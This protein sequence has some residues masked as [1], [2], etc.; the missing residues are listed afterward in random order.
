MFE[1]YHDLV[2]KVFQV[3]TPFRYHMDRWHFALE[4]LYHSRACLSYPYRP[5]PSAQSALSAA[6]ITIVN[7][8]RGAYSNA[9]LLAGFCGQFVKGCCITCYKCFL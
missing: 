4:G 2:T 7:T 3:N 9:D 1:K 8:D 5:T 6:F